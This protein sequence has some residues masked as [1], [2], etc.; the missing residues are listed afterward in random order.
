MVKIVYQGN[1]PMMGTSYAYL[2]QYETMPETR[3]LDEIA[4]EYALK[5]ADSY[6]TVYDPEDEEY[7][8]DEVRHF[9]EEDIDGWWEIYN[10]EEHDSILN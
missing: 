1:A 2:E 6:G 10:S 5:N 7:E 8:E 9:L 4:W 3:V